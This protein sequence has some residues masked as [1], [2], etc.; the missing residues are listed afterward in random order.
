MKI[1]QADSLPNRVRESEEDVDCR[2]QPL[3]QP[4]IV[5][6]NLIGLLRLALLKNGQNGSERVA[7]VQLGSK[8]MCEEVLF[9]MLFV[10]I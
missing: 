7:V 4:L 8:W 10:R 6:A 2:I 5:I 1:Y 3:R 9:R